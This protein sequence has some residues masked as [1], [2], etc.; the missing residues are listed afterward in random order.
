[1]SD[2]AK[3]TIINKTAVLQACTPRSLGRGLVRV[4]QGRK[5]AVVEE[6]KGC[7]VVVVGGGWEPVDV[8]RAASGRE[9]GLYTSWKGSYCRHDTRGARQNT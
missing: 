9:A 4:T 8:W 6:L 5:P 2:A 1:M 3:M 7:V